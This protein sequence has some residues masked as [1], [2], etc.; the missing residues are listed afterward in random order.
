MSKPV[1][2]IAVID[3]KKIK[4]TIEFSEDSEGRG[5]K[6]EISLT[7]FKKNTINKMHGFHIHEAGD[8]TDEC[9][10]ACSHFNPYNTQHGGILSKIRHVGDLGNIH[11]DVD[12]NVQM[13]FYDKM[14]KLRGTTCNII[15]RSVVIH[16][17]PDDNGLGGFP[18]SLTTGHA[19]KRLACAVIGYSKKMF[20]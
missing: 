10:G 12:G 20:S 16:E 3:D 19:G 17:D 4:G 1:Q 7:G 18:D 13:T 2:A 8:L 6:I 5:T 9:M 14:I 15:G 11:V